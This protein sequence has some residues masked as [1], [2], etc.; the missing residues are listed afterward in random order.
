MFYSPLRYPGGKGKLADFVKVIFQRNNLLEGHYVEPYAGGA[1]IALSL[2]FSG[3]ASKIIINDFDKSIFSFWHSVINENDSLCKLIN[4]SSINIH[5]WREQKEIQ[6]HK[7]DVSLLQLGFSTF[8]LNRT[9]RSGIL[10]AGVIG[11]KDQLGSYKMDARFNKKDLIGRIQKIGNLSDKILLYNLDAIELIR[12]ISS[13]LPEKTLIYFDPPY[14]VKGKELYA[15]HY[16]YDDHLLVSQMVNG[17]TEHK[18]LVSYDNEK[19]IRDMYKKNRKFTYS[20][21]YSA[22]NSTSG[23]EVMIYHKDLIIPKAGRP[24]L[25]L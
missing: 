7:E 12:T 20:L 3:Y 6:K 9:N 25:A 14:Y 21:S 19:E 17:I 2:L 24:S 16:K 23:S 11:G 8:F 13:E 18:W 22:V 5:V 1:S 10:S 4:D 15:N